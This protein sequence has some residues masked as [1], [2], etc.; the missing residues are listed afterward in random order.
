MPN[1]D[2][3]YKMKNNEF[4]RV[5]FKNHMCYHFDDI[6]ELENFDLDSLLMTLI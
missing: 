6:I 4:K 5:G 2:V 1:L 3:Q